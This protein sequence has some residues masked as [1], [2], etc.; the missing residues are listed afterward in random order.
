ME[1]G[2]LEVYLRLRLLP[3]PCTMPAFP[4]RQHFVLRLLL[5]C[6]RISAWTAGFWL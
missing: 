5:G 1:L 6:A 4:C 2:T 3:V